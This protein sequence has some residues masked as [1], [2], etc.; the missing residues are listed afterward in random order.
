MSYLYEVVAR[1]Q[2]CGD[3]RVQPSTTV[4]VFRNQAGLTFGPKEFHDD[5]SLS[6]GLNDVSASRGC[7][8]QEQILLA[9]CSNLCRSRL[10]VR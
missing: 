9:G 2:V 10:P 3:S 8:E 5:V 6:A 4:I 7:L 1:Q